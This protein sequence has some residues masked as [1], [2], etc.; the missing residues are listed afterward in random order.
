[1]DND[2]WRLVQRLADGEPHEFHEL[3]RPGK[4]EHVLLSQLDQLRALGLALQHREQTVCLQRPLELLDVRKIEQQLQSRSVNAPQ[5]VVLP[6]VDSTSEYLRRLPPT[7]DAVACLAEHQSAGRGRLG[8]HWHSPLACHWYCSLRVRMQRDREA[9]GGLSLAIGVAVKRA[10]AE[11]DIDRLRLKWPNDLMVDRRKLGGILI[12][13]LGTS[14]VI[15]GIG[16]NGTMPTAFGQRVNQPWIDLW[17]V[18]QGEPP[19]R[20]RLAGLLIEHCLE[21]VDTFDQ[22]GL[23]P[24]LSEWEQADLL[25]GEWVEISQSS[26]QLTRGQALGVDEGG[27][28]RCLLPSGK[29]KLFSAGEVSVRRDETAV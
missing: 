28:L 14:D 25:V 26:D 8:R 6:S 12:Q 19:S 3:Q 24:F 18:T 15:V 20:N 23:T 17:R 13:L 27:R 21:A 1:M 22:H 11:L 7:A 5:L 10:L 16:V 29:V 2:L 9:L 4:T